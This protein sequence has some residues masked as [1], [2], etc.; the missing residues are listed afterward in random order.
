MFLTG[1][2]HSTM[3]RLF[4]APFC[5]EIVL[6]E[7]HNVKKKLRENSLESDDFTSVL[8]SFLIR[9]TKVY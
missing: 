1:E 2:V 5:L 7:A 6:Q 9:Q 3:N 8:T 4:G